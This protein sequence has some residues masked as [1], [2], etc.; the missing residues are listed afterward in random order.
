MS[1]SRD[2]N[3]EA[4]LRVIKAGITANDIKIKFH[5]IKSNFLAEH[6]KHA[7]S[8][9]SGVGDDDLQ[10]DESFTYEVENVNTLQFVES[11]EVST[12]NSNGDGVPL[13]TVPKRRKMDR[14]NVLEDAGKAIKLVVEA[15]QQRTQNK[16]ISRD[17]DENTVGKDCLLDVIRKIFKEDDTLCIV[18]DDNFEMLPLNKIINPYVLVNVKKS[19]QLKLKSNNKF[20]ILSKHEKSLL[21]MISVLKRSPLWNER[22]SSKGTFLIVTDSQQLSQL[23]K[24]LWA[25]RIID[26]VL[27]RSYEKKV[28]IHM[29]NPFDDGNH[30]GKTPTVITTQSC[31]TKLEKL[32]QIPVKNLGK[33]KVNYVIPNRDLTPMTKTLLFLYDE[34]MKRSNTTK[35]KSNCIAEIGVYANKG[36][37]VDKSKIVY[38]QNWMW[39]T[40]APERIFPIE[41]I[42]VLFQKEVWILAGL[43]FVTIIIL[44]WFIAATRISEDIFP[45]ICRVFMMVTSLTLDGSISSIPK[46]KILRYIFV[47]YSMYALLIQTAFKTNFIQILTIPQYSNRIGSAQEVIDLNM[48][49]YVSDFTYR[50]VMYHHNLAMDN[51]L[52]KLFSFYDE[53]NLFNIVH[54]FRNAFILIQ[55]MD[56]LYSTRNK[57]IKF[58]TFIDNRVTG[59]AEVVLGTN[60]GHYYIENLNQVL[61]AL[62]ES[63]ITEKKYKDF[64]ALKKFTVDETVV[65]LNL[66]H[67]YFIFVFCAMGLTSACIAFIMECGYSIYVKRKEERQRRNK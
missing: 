39:V 17:E 65:P 53:K 19:V 28:T 26:V 15:L 31:R 1:W 3:I 35:S 20:I 55:E 2:E 43:V 62:D 36:G 64:H 60:E 46:R 12:E 8:I 37:T 22:N 16:Q 34:F 47:I 33:C 51:P 11:N 40:S 7:K 61:T 52:K 4:E 10:E 48:T 56:F 6:R 45:Q 38:Q 58:N 67:L 57:I 23:F 59:V 30:C 14:T 44:W 50:C 63:G 5:G 42:T 9:H 41:T 54:H 49:V 18:T 32:I 13:K 24:T 29:S 66:N 25:E 21:N 27:I